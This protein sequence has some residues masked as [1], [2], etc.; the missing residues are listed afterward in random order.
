MNIFILPNYSWIGV[1][2]VAQWKQ[3]WLVYM[4]MQVWS[5]AFLRGLR[6]QHCCELWCRSQ[7]WLRT[8]VAVAVAVAQAGSCSSNST[9]SLGNSID[10]TCGPKKQKKKKKKNYSWIMDGIYDPTKSLILTIRHTSF[11]HNLPF[12]FMIT[13]HA[14]VS[15]KT[16]SL[17][18][19][20]LF[21][22][23]SHIK[24]ILWGQHY[25]DSKIKQGHHICKKI[26]SQYHWT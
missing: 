2:V 15:G 12:N 3:T 21:L 9:P 24:H 20:S 8:R 4:R 18:S 10:H 19:I 1:P 22:E 6:V 23:Q 26:T 7:T 25:P 13:L 17:C 16:N 11:W 14:C 5:L